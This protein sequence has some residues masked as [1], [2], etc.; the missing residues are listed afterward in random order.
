MFIAFLVLSILVA[1]P[2]A[3][4]LRP[5]KHSPLIF[6]TGGSFMFLLGTMGGWA[7]RQDL[8]SGYVHFN[9]RLLGEVHAVSMQQPLKYWMIV[10]ML[11]ALSVS[12]AGFGLAGIG[13]CFR[14]KAGGGSR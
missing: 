10:L 13:L 6:A 11:Y 8:Q 4:T 12:I 1:V 7:L 14:K 3:R 5:P 9:G 2:I